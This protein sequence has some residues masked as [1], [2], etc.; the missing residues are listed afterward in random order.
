MKRVLKTVI[1]SLFCPFV[2]SPTRPSRRKITHK[3][4]DCERGLI[5]GGKIFLERLD[6]LEG[7]DFLEE[8]EG[9][10]GLELI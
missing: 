1:N 9:L 7:L 2:P 6:G 4:R 10:E 5:E 3:T 8:L